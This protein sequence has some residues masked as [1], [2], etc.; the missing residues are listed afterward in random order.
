MIKFFFPALL[1]IFYSCHRPVTIG[2]VERIDPSLDSIIAPGSKAEIIAEGFKWTEGPLWIADKNM[3]LFS[4]VFANKVF[5]W[6]QEKGTETY[7]SP[8]GYT[9]EKAREAELGSNGLLLNKEGKLVLC[10]HGNRQVALM[11]ADLG[12]PKPIYKTIAASYENKKLNSPNDATYNSAGELFFTDPPYGLEKNMADPLKE[13]SFQG[14]YKV[15]A[16]GQLT[17]LC[18]SITRPNGIAFFPGDSSLLIA[19]SD[20]TKPYWYYFDIKN[21]SFANG[22]VFYDATT[23]LSQGKGLPDGLKIDKQGNVFASGPGGIFIFNRQG[24]LLGKISLPIAASN[25]AF[26]PDQKTLFI[27]ATNYVLKLKMR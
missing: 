26:S 10:Q 13:I 8:S 25:C 22:K 19:N 11:D 27:T 3:L 1:C 9:G 14:V 4:D 20:S 17:L 23:A 24:K 18:D 5:K 7:V 2:N 15:T 6:S 12:N 21:G 16:P